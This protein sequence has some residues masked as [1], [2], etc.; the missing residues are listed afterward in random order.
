MTSTQLFLRKQ[1]EIDVAKMKEEAR[2]LEEQAAAQAA[3]RQDEEQRDA[4]DAAGAGAEDTESAV[5]SD[6]AVAVEKLTACTPELDG[7]VHSDASALAM[8][9][10]VEREREAAALKIQQ[11]V[12]R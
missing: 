3:R 11:V 12:R 4:D 5:D 10:K 7:A 9:R 2:R 1:E 6:G 8:R